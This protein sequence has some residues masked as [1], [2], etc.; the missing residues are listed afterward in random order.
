MMKNLTNKFALIALMASA[1]AMAATDGTLD[2]TQ[3]QGS[4]D[5]TLTVTEVVQVS[6]PNGDIPI[7]YSTTTTTPVTEEFCIYTNAADGGVGVAIGVLN[8]N[9]AGASQP[10]VLKSGANEI[11]YSFDFETQAGTSL[12]SNIDEDGLAEIATTTANTTSATC[13][14]GNSHQ[15]VVTVPSANMAAAPVGSYSDTITV[16]VQPAL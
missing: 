1:S 11:E 16:T 13:A 10:A 14:G 15:L 12:A 5:V 9:S 6:F 8:D 4:A 3:S 2:G 7:A